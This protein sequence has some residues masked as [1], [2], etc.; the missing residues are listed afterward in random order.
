VFVPREAGSGKREA[1]TAPAP[2]TV[3]NDDASSPA[4]PFPLPPSPFPV[5]TSPEG[6]GKRR[7]GRRGGRRGRGGEGSNQPGSQ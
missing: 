7:R 2:R 6:S 5:P 1:G 3:S 4:S